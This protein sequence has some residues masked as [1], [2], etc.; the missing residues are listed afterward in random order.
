MS[1]GSPGSFAA[2]S[3]PRRGS[4]AIGEGV[5]ISQPNRRPAADWLLSSRWS[6]T[7]QVPAA[8]RHNLG[9]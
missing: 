4:E 3:W 2:R 5:K 6:I 1:S 9:L 7:I 8:N